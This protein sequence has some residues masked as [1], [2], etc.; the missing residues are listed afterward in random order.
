MSAG[1]Q[2]AS[3]LNVS[4]FLSY[5]QPAGF[6]ITS[7]DICS[8]ERAYGSS[9]SSSSE[10]DSTTSSTNALPS[11]EKI[12]GFVWDQAHRITNKTNNHLWVKVTRTR[13]ASRKGLSACMDFG[14][15]ARRTPYVLSQPAAELIEDPM[16]AIQVLQET[17]SWA[18]LGC[19]CFF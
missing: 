19:I 18:E 10:S 2:D 17:Q 15:S 9:D 11:S 3:M 7:N 14:E 6:T 1:V 13:V 16:Q 12:P 8:Y 5:G 4:Q